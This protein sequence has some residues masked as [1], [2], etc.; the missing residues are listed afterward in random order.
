[1]F[2]SSSKGIVWGEEALFYYDIKQ[3]KV[4]LI[5][6]KQTSNVVFDS[7]KD[8][9]YYCKENRPQIIEKYSIKT[10]ERSVIITKK[11][12]YRC[13]LIACVFLWMI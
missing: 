10:G 4:I 3:N 8:E 1:M 13:L 9:V 6:E 7:L 2:G 12:F 5:N 11:K